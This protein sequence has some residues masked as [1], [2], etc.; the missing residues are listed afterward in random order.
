M[1]SVTITVSGTDPTVSIQ[2]EDED[3]TVVLGG[4]EIELEAMS[5]DVDS[6]A[7]TAD[8]AVGTFSPSVA[9]RRC[10]LDYDLDGAGC[11]GGHSGGHL[12]LDCD[13]QRRGHRQ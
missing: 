8:P 7:W 11:N 2:T 1:A 3:Q 9:D 12:D 5:A 4:A 13:R 6:H 10:D